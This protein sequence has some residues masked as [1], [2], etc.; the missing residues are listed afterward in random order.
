MSK[1]FAIFGN[2]VSHSK[3]PNMH[4]DA[5]RFIGCDAVYKKHLLNDGE[6]IAK[7][8]L[9]HGYSGANITVPFKEIAF[10]KADEV[11]GIG[12]KIKAVNTYINE[13][14]KI[15]AYNT[16]A[17]GFLKAIQDFKDVKNV[18]ILGAGGTAKAASIALYEVGKSVYVLNRSKEKL[19]FFEAWDIKCYSH[20]DFEISDFD[21]V[22]NATSAGLDNDDLPFIKENLEPVL[23]NAK[24]AY[25]C[26]YGKMTPFL[27]LAQKNGC[28]I[29][30]GTDMLLYQGVLA[31]EL[32]VGKRADEELIGIMRRALEKV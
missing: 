18:L 13:D 8:F 6:S 12:L 28:E 24:Y 30:D 2:P 27:K 17:P 7:E 11:R 32:F 3:S 29:K 23:K 4:N 14:G 26:I 1:K 31:F 15:I 19:S 25:D 21:L 20:D 9:K 22:V 5:F 10:K 16:D